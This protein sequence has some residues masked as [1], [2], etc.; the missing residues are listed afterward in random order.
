MS[1]GPASVVVALIATLLLLLPRPA[2]AFPW[3][4]Q[5]GYT[6]CGSC[7]LD[8]SGA[9]ILTSYGRAQSE[10]LL[11][12]RYAGEPADPGRFGEFGFGAITLPEQLLLQADVRGAYIPVPNDPRYILMQA[13]LRV[14]L[15]IGPVVA[16]A[17]AGV[18]DEGAQGAWFTSNEGGWNAVMRDAWVGVEP[19]KGVLVRAGRMNLPFGIRTEEH[20]LH[21]RA[22]TRT[23]TNDDQQ[24]GVSVATTQRRWRGE[25][26][27]IAGNFQVAPDDYRERGYSLFAAWDP[28]RRFEIGV[29]S[30]VTH[31]ALDVETL[32]P[33]T[34]H[35]HGLFARGAPHEKVSVLGEADWLIN[36]SEGDGSM[37]AVAAIE[38]DVEV[39]QGLHTRAI[40]SWCEPTFADDEAGIPTGWLAVQ[41]FAAPRVDIRLDALHGSISCLPG[42]ERRFMGLGQV[43][44]FL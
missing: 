23:T 7:H 15:D 12:T 28:T 39:V 32:A 14:G 18:V 1:R 6:N 20:T 25:I 10:V 22:V 19:A 21:T 44:F 36:R 40:G 26:M 4:I 24:Y 31:A 29:S 27:G 42:A 34:R 35:A 16:Y 41:W 9:G 11:R 17:S 5:H 13:D 2:A 43:H 38:V 37:G 8:P 30:L 3:M 33:R